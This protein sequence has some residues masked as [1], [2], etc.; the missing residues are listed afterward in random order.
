[1]AKENDKK[2]KKKDSH[3][4]KLLREQIEN[5]RTSLDKIPSILEFVENKKYLGLPYKL[6]DIQKLVLKCF[7]RNS[8]GNENLQ[9][10]QQDIDLIKRNNLDSA[11]KGNLIE[12]W[13][14]QQ[15][16]RELVLVWGR[17]CLSEDAEIVDIYTG[18]IWKLGE[19]WNYGKTKIETQTFDEQLG[20][21]VVMKNCNLIYQ[22]RKDIYRICLS[23]GYEIEATDNHPLFT[24]SGWLQV[25]DLKVK[26]KIGIATSQ[27]FFGKDDTLSENEACL[28]GYFSSSCFDST[29]EF[30][31]SV[32]GQGKVFEHFKECAK[33]THSNLH[34]DKE[35]KDRIKSFDQ[36]QYTVIL[37]EISENHQYGIVDKLL[38]YNGLKNKENSQKFVPARIFTASK[39]L[40][41]A[42]L[43]S[44][45]S[46]NAAFTCNKSSKKITAKIEIDFYNSQIA[47]QIQ[48][49]LNRFGIISNIKNKLSTASQTYTL[50]INKNNHV[51]RFVQEIGFLNYD[52]EMHGVLENI[53]N[54]KI[55]QQ[56]I[57][58]DIISIKKIGQKRTFDIQVSH[59][60]HLQNFVANGI[61]CH[62]CI[63]EDGI[64]IDA[65][66]GE[67]FTFKQAWEEQRIISSWTYDEK[68][69]KMVIID[70]CGVIQQGRRVV[71]KITSSTGHEIEVTD[72]HPM[73]TDRGWVECKHLNTGDRIAITESIPF[74]GNSDAISEDEAAILGYITGDGCCSQSSVFFTAK[75]EEIRADLENRLNRL[76]DNLELVSDVWTKADS[77][78]YAYKIRSKEFVTRAYYDEKKQRR[79]STRDKNDLVKLLIKHEIM[80]KTS[81][82]KQVP[83]ELFNCPKN[84]VSAYLRSLFSCDGWVHYYN[85]TNQANMSVGFASINKSQVQAVQ[86]LLQKFGIIAT[87]RTRKQKTKIKTEGKLF[88]YDCLSYCL[89]FKK[90]RHIKT[91]FSEIG[92]IGK[93]SNVNHLIENLIKNAK[94]ERDIRRPF[95]FSKIKSINCIGE[96]EV[97]DLQVSDQ[98]HLQNFVCQGFHVKN[99]GKDF[100]CSIIALYEAMRLL[101]LPGGDPYKIYNLGSATPF[102]ILTIANSSAQAKIL[103]REIKD[104]VL[105]SEYF[106]D[107]ILPEGVTSDAIHFLTPEDRRRNEELAEKGFSPNLG[108][109]VVRSGHSNSD[110]LVGIS[111]YVLLLDEIGLYKNTAGSSSGDSIFNSLAPAVKTYVRDVPRLDD[112]NN[113]ILDSDGKPISDKIY[114]G[115]I[116]CLSTPRG[117][118]GIFYNL[119]QNHNEVDHRLVC[120]AAT[121][122]VN[123]MQS[124][125]ALMAAFPSMPEEK[126]RMEFGAEFSGTAG[127][128]FFAE[129]AVE[130]CFSDKTLK[131]RD[132]GKPGVYHFAHLDPATS[133]HN[134]ALVMAHKETYFDREAGK[135][136]W[137]IIV[138]HIKY[139]SPSPGK[140]ILVDEVDD[141]VIELNGR[142]CLGVVTY[143]HFNSHSSIEKL[144]KKGVPTKMTP[145][146]KRYKNIIY[147][148]LYQLVIQRK[149]LI[150]NHLLLKN[151]MKNLQRKW[152]NSG[153]KVYPKRD[154]DVTTDDIVDALAGACFNC[155]E[156]EM[157]KT[158]QGK[159]VNLPVNGNNN[160]VWRSMQGIPYGVGPGG[161]VANKMDKI[162]SYPNRGV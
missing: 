25:K 1:M 9:L 136:D 155:V 26:D 148:H 20:K 124:K 73:L 100:L 23:N 28:L 83:N 67:K 157:N 85:K 116:I 7:Y 156:K 53:Q 69:N 80:G 142:F 122:Q 43:K 150:P 10:T 121:W 35:A 75:N 114:D 138:D 13:N 4:F 118:E 62:N 74:F 154:G 153:Y 47:K 22:G 146:T 104:K 49:L 2:N 61:L 46:C 97:Y 68:Q 149:L 21:F 159:L 27:E 134:Y 99:S 145:F 15:D 129:D 108:S 84:V 33:S 119:Y 140:P 105:Q 113:P 102:T 65:R 57:F 37:K 107:K 126:F 86:V 11:D 132:F 59:L 34:I 54:K 45:F 120:Q 42:Y 137:K 3:M 117:K 66:T 101:E 160:M 36:R 18:K 72:N 71:Y 51:L 81:R 88:N 5:E 147:D 103:F 38:V 87:I 98:E 29:G 89:E 50:S 41:V 30:I 40:I 96:K 109:I 14:R 17:R 92:F 39:K 94:Y 158:P 55:E 8:L 19:L 115:K 60:P 31:A 12:K 76:S 135:K 6:F 52:E 70:N 58:V 112:K 56:P 44:L 152:L 127:E 16:F 32:R 128:N 24:P 162:K 82:N 143:D 123:P 79:I 78:K 131:L 110:T 48:H 161:Q 93:N 63:S 139:W 144:R 77:K 95:I 151:E 125:E 106:K 130:D 111:C 90:Y 64:L 91:F 141:Y 133:S